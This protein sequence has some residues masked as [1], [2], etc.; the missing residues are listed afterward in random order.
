MTCITGGTGIAEALH[1]NLK[2]TM[3][4]AIERLSNCPFRRAVL[5][6]IGVEIAGSENKALSLQLLRLLHGSPVFDFR[7][8]Y[9]TGIMRSSP[10][11]S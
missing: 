11:E 8:F 1:E 4:S 5:S 7:T 10:G 6:C 3:A 2:E 9:G